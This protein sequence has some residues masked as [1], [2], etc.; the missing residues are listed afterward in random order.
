MNP[1]ERWFSDQ[2][3]ASICAI[4]DSN[5]KDKY[6]EAEATLNELM[7]PSPEDP[8]LINALG[9]YRRENGIYSPPGILLG[10]LS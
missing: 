4:L 8:V 5:Q 7:Q 10:M 1:K 2:R 6:E 9:V 3:F